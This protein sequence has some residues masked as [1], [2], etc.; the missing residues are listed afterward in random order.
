MATCQK[1]CWSGRRKSYFSASCSTEPSSY[2][3]KSERGPSNNDRVIPKL[4]LSCKSVF[5]ISN[6]SS[7][8]CGVWSVC[9]QAI[10][11]ALSRSWHLLLY[12]SPRCLTL[13]T[14]CQFHLYFHHGFHLLN[15]FSSRS[16]PAAFQHLSPP[17]IVFHQQYSQ[18]SAP[19]D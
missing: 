7:I 14:L 12:I 3:Q 16:L 6:L 2:E 5:G 1:M 18:Y 19:N 4:F 17:F 13:S 8:V 11:S 9:F 15:Y 10:H